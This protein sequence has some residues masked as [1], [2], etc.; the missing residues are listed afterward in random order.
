VEETEF[1][2]IARIIDAV[3]SMLLMTYYKSLFYWFC[4]K[5]QRPQPELEQYCS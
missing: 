4:S 5:T 2:I 3:H 1:R